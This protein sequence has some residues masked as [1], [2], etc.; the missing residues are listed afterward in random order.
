MTDETTDR[1]NGP[2]VWNIDGT[3][4][5]D[6]FKEHLAKSKPD[7]EPAA[8]DVVPL[9]DALIRLL[10]EY[11]LQAE[12]IGAQQNG[13][14]MLF[15]RQRDLKGKWQLAQNRRELVR[16]PEGQQG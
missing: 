9:D 7:P 10:E 5:G 14:L 13:A 1:P 4:L 12:S 11:R 2:P 15:V 6:K 16:T 8:P 3:A